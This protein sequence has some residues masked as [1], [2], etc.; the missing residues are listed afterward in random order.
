MSKQ[1]NFFSQEYLQN[2]ER[3]PINWDKYSLPF[4]SQMTSFGD[5]SYHSHEFFEI[6]Y[7][8]AGTIH[9]VIE[10]T[11]SI[12]T[13]GDLFI[14]PPN[15]YHGFKRELNI[16]CFHRDTLV[17]ENL[18]REV[19]DALS[20]TLFQTLTGKAFQYFHLS[21]EQLQSLNQLF[22]FFHKKPTTDQADAKMFAKIILTN[23]LGSFVMQQLST[24]T[25]TPS[26]CEA[27]QHNLTFCVYNHQEIS[28]AISHFHYNK[29]YLCRLFKKETG[30]TMTEYVNDIKLKRA[31]SLLEHTAMPISKIVLELNFS[32]ESYFFKIFREKYQCSPLQYRKKI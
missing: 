25:P 16:E 11:Q 22:S 29:A 4:S 23:I 14:I 28:D 15:I 13:V 2:S 5:E 6:F 1:P 12:L 21:E 7:I 3:L 18:L 10:T 32:S 20:P 30:K 24:Q 27:L 9:H 19:C 8:S 26:L 31:K 17:G